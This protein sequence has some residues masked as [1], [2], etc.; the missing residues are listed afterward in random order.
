MR[1][2]LTVA[3]GQEVIDES[4]FENGDDPLGDQ[5]IR[6]HTPLQWRVVVFGVLGL[7]FLGFLVHDLIDGTYGR[8]FWGAVLVAICGAGI[9][10]ELKNRR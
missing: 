3:D 9:A 4:P 7:V 6:R 1:W 10:R 8:A 2:V 5:G